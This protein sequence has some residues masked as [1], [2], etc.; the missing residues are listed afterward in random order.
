M[1]DA[2]P[3]RLFAVKP[4]IFA[5]PGATIIIPIEAPRNW[6]APKRFAAEIPTRIG[7]NQ[8]GAADIN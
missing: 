3:I 2:F 8:K 6:F 7:K 4:I 5:V 1:V